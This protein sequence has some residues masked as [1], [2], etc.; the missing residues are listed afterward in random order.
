MVRS[1]EVILLL[2]IF[3]LNCGRKWLALRM[4][5]ATSCGKNYT[6]K[7]NSHNDL[8]GSNFPR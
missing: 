4:V 8:L 5:P 2:E 1:L 7:A 3:S 6:N